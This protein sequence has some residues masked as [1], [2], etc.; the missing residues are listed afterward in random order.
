MVKRSSVPLE[1]PIGEE[2]LDFL[3]LALIA[4]QDVLP[5]TERLQKLAKKRRELYN[6][7]WKLYE[8]AKE[9]A[10]TDRLTGLRNRIAFDFAIESALALRSRSEN[11]P[12]A[13]AVMDID[14][15]KRIN[16]SHGHAIGDRV[17]EALGRL[18]LRRVRRSDFCARYGG[19]EFV[20]LFEYTS[21]EGK[22]AD[23]LHAFTRAL[24]S[25]RRSV[26]R[27]RITNDKGERVLVS[28]SFGYAIW[29][30]EESGEDLFRRADRAL[31]N[32]KAAGRNRLTFASD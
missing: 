27:L 7:L 21:E 13:L 11:S 26:L 2:D 25:F 30:G 29:N 5:T 19:E 12:L 14:H 4:P 23:Y 18:F 6:A 8:E 17:L 22:E 16:D 3:D 24:E 32:A 9:H 31:Y 10:L 20:F 28:A 15:F 1:G